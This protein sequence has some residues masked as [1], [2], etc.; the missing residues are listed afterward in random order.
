M[1][2]NPWEN[3]CE[4]CAFKTVPK[5]SSEK[6]FKKAD[7]Q[8]VST[9]NSPYYEHI[10]SVHPLITSGRC[11]LWFVREQEGKKPLPDTIRDTANSENMIHFM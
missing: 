1:F 6:G 8:T 9:A 4:K 11:E 7:A 10:R 3:R 5:C 2:R